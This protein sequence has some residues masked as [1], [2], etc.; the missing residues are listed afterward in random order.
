MRVVQIQGIFLIDSTLTPTRQREREVLVDC[1]ELGIG[2]FAM[3]FRV[4]EMIGVLLMACTLAPGAALAHTG[5]GPTG[6]FT[7]GLVHPFAGIDHL[8]V[9]L[10]VGW[11]AA[12]MGGYAR[13][14]LPL[15]FVSAMALGSAVQQWGIVWSEAEVLVSLSVVMMGG[16]LLRNWRTAMV[17]AMMGVTAFA[18]FHGYVHAAEM[19]HETGAIAYASGFLTATEMLQTA[20]FGLGRWTCRYRWPRLTFGMLCAGVGTYLLTG[21]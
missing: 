9:L 11:W 13:W 10:A 21:V 8:L 15:N 4:W 19:G 17:P 14:L 7:A 3:N 2:G 18:L 1:F 20:G 5:I 6:G 16:V 12:M